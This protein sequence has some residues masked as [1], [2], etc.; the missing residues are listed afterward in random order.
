MPPIPTKAAAYK[1]TTFGSAFLKARAAVPLG[2]A[3]VALWDLDKAETRAEAELLAG[4]AR[5]VLEKELA[6]LDAIVKRGIEDEG[7]K[8]KV[9]GYRLF[10]C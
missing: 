7:R 8:I 5:T 1:K 4:A 9:N 6:E 3:A 10:V 2:A